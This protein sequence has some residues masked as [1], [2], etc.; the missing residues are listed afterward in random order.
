MGGRNK[1]LSD[2][3]IMRVKR[4][5][6]NAITVNPKPIEA[7]AFVKSK[8]NL[9]VSDRTI[10]R[11]TC[12]IKPLIFETIKN[13][14]A[15][16]EIIIQRDYLADRKHDGYR[17]I[18]NLLMS[19][20]PQRRI[21]ASHKL[22]AEAWKELGGGGQ[23]NNPKKQSIRIKYHSMGPGDTS[24]MDGHDKI[25]LDWV[26]IYIHGC[27]DGCSRLFKWL[28]AGYTN[29][30]PKVVLHYFLDTI[31]E[32]YAQQGLLNVLGMEDGRFE[33]STD[34]DEE[35]LMMEESGSH[36][37]LDKT[38]PID[39]KMAPDLDISMEAMEPELAPDLDLSMEDLSRQEESEGSEREQMLD[40][41]DSDEIDISAVTDYK[42]WQGPKE[43]PEFDCI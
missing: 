30:K 4:L 8:M 10:R 28:K 34:E 41:F 33:Y 29:R 40:D 17:K 23:Y 5:Y 35:E 38:S 31:E 1:K 15:L 2:E 7:V 26:G 43:S 6:L 24:H 13:K 18:R 37:Y 3:Q 39:L 36:N 42:K 20:D 25:G 19:G 22:V 9:E 16:I 32:E 14:T 11:Y 27:V 21:S 12:D